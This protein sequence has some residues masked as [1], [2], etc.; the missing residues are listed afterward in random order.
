MKHLEGIYV[1]ST[2]I[3]RRG[4]EEQRNGEGNGVKRDSSV[5]DFSAVTMCQ[6]L[7]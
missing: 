2:L 3:L 7:F 4:H 1:L 6:A 5:K